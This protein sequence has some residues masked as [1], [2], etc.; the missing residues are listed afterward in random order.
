VQ[1][2]FEIDPA[3]D[4]PLERGR[5]DEE[6][7][8]EDELARAA[9]F[10]FRG[11]APVPD[12][13]LSW[14]RLLRPYAVRRAGVAE[15]ADAAGLG[16]VGPRGPWRFESSRPHHVGGADRVSHRRED[17][18]PDGSGEAEQAEVPGAHVPRPFDLARPLPA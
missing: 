16:P 10:E 12:E 6:Q 4:E 11:A 1:S 18:E 15:L 14:I 7:D 3:F 13:P 8:L 5:V 2:E 9:Q 17:R